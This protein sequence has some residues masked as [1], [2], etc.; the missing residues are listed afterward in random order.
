MGSIMKKTKKHYKVGDSVWI[1]GVSAGPG[2]NRPTK[3]SI[4]HQMEIDNYAG[5]HYVIAISNGIEDL[6]EVRTWEEISQDEKGPIG[7][8]RELLM[9]DPVT[10]KKLIRTGMRL[11]DVDLNPDLSGEDDEELN[12]DQD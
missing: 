2:Y 6:L 5:V 12:Q 10:Q 1:Y 8:F 11:P 4:V 9:N 3:G 7:S